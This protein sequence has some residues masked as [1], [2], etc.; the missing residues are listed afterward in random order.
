MNI[1]F[2]TNKSE[3]TLNDSVDMNRYFIKFLKYHSLY[4][5]VT[6]FNIEGFAD[7]RGDEWDNYELSNKRAEAVANYLKKFYPN[8]KIYISARGEMNSKETKDSLELQKDRCVRIFFNENPLNRALNLCGAN[9]YVLDQS[10][11]M[12]KDGEW[13]IL[14]DY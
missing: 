14:Q 2:Q 9:S 7:C 6:N 13:N 8:I 3:L 10:G 1:Y 11:S 4:E 12:N 5:K